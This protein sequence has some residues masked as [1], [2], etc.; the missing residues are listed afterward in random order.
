MNQEIAIKK[1]LL[2]IKMLNLFQEESPIEENIRMELLSLFKHYCNLSFVV[3]WEDRGIN[4]TA[5]NSHP[6]ARI[7]QNG[8]VLE[9]FEN[10]KQA[11]KKYSY[12][13]DTIPRAIKDNR[14]TGIRRGH[15][16]YWDFINK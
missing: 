10:I 9:I 2:E 14:P 13:H 5:H 4:L 1:I 3:G 6:V 15:K 11:S 7:T 16:Y 12:H 8:V